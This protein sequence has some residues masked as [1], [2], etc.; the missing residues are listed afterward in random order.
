MDRLHTG[1]EMRAWSRAARARGERVGFVP[2][3]GYLHE[4]H[5][6][7]VRVAHEHADRVVVSIFVNPTQFAP[8]E[9]LSRYPRDPDGDLAKCRAEDVDA[10]F[11]PPVE[12]MYPPGSQTFVTVEELTR[13]L[14]G[15]DRPTHFR[16]VTTVVSLLFHL[17]EPDVAVFGEKDYQQLRVVQRMVRDQGFPVEV[18]PGPLVREP[19]GV[20]MSSRNAYL[21]AEERAQAVVLNRSLAWAREQVAAGCPVAPA[22][23]AEVRARIEAA[24]L[25]RV[26]YVALVD[27]DDLRELDG[28]TERPARLAVA[29]R[30]GRT[31][32]LDNVQLVPM[33]DRWTT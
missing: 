20:A 19:D 14:C 1:A 3:M 31:R 24:P 8:G 22:L 28:P 18:V 29:V 11:L 2:T 9:D 27:D 15:A 33:V 12:E 32:L 13:G 25:A 23:A 17:V 26:D 30:F 21:S 7:L 10:V 5:L 6:G 4:G 16:G